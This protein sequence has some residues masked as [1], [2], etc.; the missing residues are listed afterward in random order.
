MAAFGRQVITVLLPLKQSTDAK[1]TPPRE[2]VTRLSR[3]P[4]WSP[5]IDFVTT[6]ESSHW[7]NHEGATGKTRQPREIDLVSTGFQPPDR[8]FAAAGRGKSASIV[9]YRHGLQANIGVEFDFGTV[10]KKCFM[11]PANVSGPDYGHHLLLSVPGRSALLHIP[12]DFSDTF[13][14]EQHQTPYDLSSPTLVA[15]RLSEETIVQVTESGV[16][17]LSSSKR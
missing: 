4:N 9:E 11:L 14:V 15:T 10:V 1:Q 3:I 13:D 8:V 17:F 12:P 16:V 6:N 5:T 2:K 7:D